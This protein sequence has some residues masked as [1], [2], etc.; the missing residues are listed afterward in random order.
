MERV[1]LLSIWF[2][3]ALVRA[4]HETST[5]KGAGPTF[6]YRWCSSLSS[7]GMRWLSWYSQT[8][9]VKSLLSVWYSCYTGDQFPVSRFALAWTQSTVRPCHTSCSKSARGPDSGVFCPVWSDSLLSL[10]IQLITNVVS[11]QRQ[12]RYLVQ[13]IPGIQWPLLLEVSG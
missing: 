5:W 1:P 10:S 12:E 6:P 13:G 9:V 8:I 3:L 11:S 2:P 7:M 4:A